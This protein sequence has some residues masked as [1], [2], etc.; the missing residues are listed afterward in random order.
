MATEHETEYSRNG[1]F[2]KLNIRFKYWMLVTTA[3]LVLILTGLF[4]T[5]VFGKFSRLAKESAKERFSL[6]TQHAVA[7]IA[8]LVGDVAQKVAMLSS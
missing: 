6:V 7:E 4:L 8:N 3:A 1:T 2:V 5:M